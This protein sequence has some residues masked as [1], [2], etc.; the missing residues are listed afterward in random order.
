MKRKLSE[1]DHP[2]PSE[3]P[4]KVKQEDQSIDF[5]QDVK[6]KLGTASRTG[7][8]CDRCRT[9]D[10]ITGKATVRGYVESLES[11]LVELE[12]QNQELQAQVRLLGGHVKP[13]SRSATS[14]SDRLPRTAN[15]TPTLRPQSSFSSLTASGLP[16]RGSSQNRVETTQRSENVNGILGDRG[17][18]DDSRNAPGGNTYFGISSGNSL[19]STV[20]GTSMNVL[21]MEI[22]L[23]DYLSPDIDEPDP[24]HAGLRLYNKSYHAFVQTAFGW[25]PKV[26]EVKLPPKS[27]GFH[28]AEIFFRIT[29]PFCPV[30]HKPTFMK[31][32]NRM[33]DD[34]TFKPLDA[35]TALVHAMFATCYWQF[36]SRNARDAEHQKE[37]NASS[38]LH[39][40]YALGFFPQLMA[41]H[42]LADVQ[43]LALLCIHLRNFPKPGASWML[44]SIT[45]NLAIELGLHRSAKN[46]PATVKRNLLEIEIRKRV[47]WTI[48]WIHVL[49]GGSLGR[50]MALKSGDW[51]VE[52]P[53]PIDDDLLS[54]NSMDTS[55]PGKCN[56]TVGMENF[57]VMPIY[58]D[59]YNNIYA[60]TR[61]PQ[62]YEAMVRDLE[63][64]I[65]E[66]KK[67]WPRELVD[68]SAAE[69]ELGRIHVQYLYLWQLHIRLLLRHPS[70]SLASSK[71]LNAEN[72]TVCLEVSKEILEHVKILQKWKGMDIT[73][74]TF[75]LFVLA[76]ATTLYGHCERK[77]QISLRDLEILK[78][79]MRDW[80]CIIFELDSLLGAG[81]RLANRVNQLVSETLT[82]LSQ[83]MIARAAPPP[84]VPQASKASTQ[85]S[86]Q[87]DQ[88][89]INNSYQSYPHYSRMNSNGQAKAS[90]PE[91]RYVQ[92]SSDLVQAY[93]NPQQYAYQAPYESSRNNF[94]PSLQQSNPLAT[95]A[96]AANAYMSTY[97]PNTFPNN[98]PSQN[99]DPYQ[100]P[101]SPSSWRQ[102]TGNVL[103]NF[104][105]APS[106]FM[107]SASALMQMGSSGTSDMNMP[108][109]NTSGDTALWPW[110]VSEYNAGNG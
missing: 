17:R 14:L 49:V 7:T 28:F 110:V 63:K 109:G 94:A 56:F 96:T 76:I 85:S 46:W 36:A 40:H 5:S 51:D 92:T 30:A 58:I 43:A 6:K 98:Y 93:P 42:K 60:V 21:G 59:L 3:T 20:R 29:H 84:H 41:S 54:E 12:N 9:T 71:Q 79:D 65:E 68:E 64:R 108:Q 16:L 97:P 105:N 52:M 62:D 104:E 25:G 106:D 107:S 55:A 99:S 100:I 102:F 87:L 81:N 77:A 18:L 11:R 70:L 88:I 22:D 80:L 27:E 37:L 4:I 103:P 91:N 47:F 78:Q 86:I 66:F 53:E 45:L 67:G 32:L 33:Y 2:S 39:Y 19:L 1:R 50:P 15:G 31:L 90:T 48:N 101:G 75:A 8:A 44:T 35:E 23:T 73:W 83:H 69:N 26:L 57:K 34:P 74:Q 72:L 24:S 61:T 82:E 89:P 10:R 95:T 38:N 13:L